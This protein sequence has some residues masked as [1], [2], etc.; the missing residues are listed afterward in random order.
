M[1]KLILLAIKIIPLFTLY[2]GLT[3]GEVRLK[4]IFNLGK[5]F[6]TQYEIKEIT[7]NVITFYQE[8][9]DQLPD[10]SDFSN[11]INNMYSNH[12]S[13]ITRQVFGKSS[14]D[15]SKDLWDTPYAL[16]INDYDGTVKI[17]SAGQDTILDTK[18][19]ISFGFEISVPS[20][21][22]E[23]EEKIDYNSESLTDDEYNEINYEPE[24]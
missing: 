1:K 12:Y 2:K 10:P 24:N 3:G 23:E 14:S 17:I 22:Q 5:T 16:K 18:D 13:I 4:S 7:N 19:D 8:N 6:F 20:N 15:L 9:N 21:L 11:Y